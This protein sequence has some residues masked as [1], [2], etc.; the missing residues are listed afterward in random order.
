MKNTEKIPKLK[1]GSK[2]TKRDKQDLKIKLPMPQ[3]KFPNH[4]TIPEKS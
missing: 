4:H 3:N 2:T 1:G